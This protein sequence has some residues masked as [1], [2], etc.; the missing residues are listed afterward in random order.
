MS[1]VCGNILFQYKPIRVSSNE[2]LKEVMSTCYIASNKIA[3]SI[4]ELNRIIFQFDKYVSIVIIDKLSRNE[5]PNRVKI[6]ILEDFRD[7]ISHRYIS[8]LDEIAQ[9]IQ[10]C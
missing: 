1:L 5:F 10:P 3:Q 4:E 8:R 9:R 6:K 2:L 7:S